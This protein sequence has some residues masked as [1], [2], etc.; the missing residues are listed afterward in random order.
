[1]SYKITLEEIHD[2]GQNNIDSLY[3]DDFI[4]PE[5][6]ES[7]TKSVTST[8]IIR[9]F[10]S[11]MVVMGWGESSVFGSLNEIY[12]DYEFSK[13]AKDENEFDECY[14]DNE[15]KNPEK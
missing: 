10:I 6:V 9:T 15:D 7:Y 1:M 3:D 2:D 14:E 4:S 8:S 5:K 13:E 12:E 11:M